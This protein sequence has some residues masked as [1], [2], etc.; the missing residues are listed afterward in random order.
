M[1]K[2]VEQCYGVHNI[3]GS[4]PIAAITLL[5]AI[6]KQH[7]IAASNVK[8]EQCCGIAPGPA[9]GVDSTSIFDF[10]NGLNE[11]MY[12]VKRVIALPC[13]SLATPLKSELS[14]IMTQ[15]NNR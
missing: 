10:F 7:K 11:R 2:Q 13:Q 12:G 5:P 4:N 14:V 9:G 8:A 3:A 6:I 15:C 1:L